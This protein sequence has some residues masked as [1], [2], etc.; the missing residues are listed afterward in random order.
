MNKM[1]STNSDIAFKS[2]HLSKTKVSS[3]LSISKYLYINKHPSFFII[4]VSKLIQILPQLIIIRH[5]FR[6]VRNT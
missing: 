4:D 1:N 6:R 2:Q 5:T 3:F